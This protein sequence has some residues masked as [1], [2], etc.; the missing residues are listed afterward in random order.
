MTHALEI[1]PAMSTVLPPSASPVVSPAVSTV[2]PATPLASQPL[3]DRSGMRPMRTPSLGGR[4]TSA[5]G[6]RHTRQASALKLARAKG[7]N[8]GLMGRTRSHSHTLDV[9]LP[10]HS[11][12]GLVAL[13]VTALPISETPDPSP[14][15]RGM[16]RSSTS[17]ALHAASL[18]D[19]EDEKKDAVANVKINPEE[20]GKLD[21][22][23]QLRLLAM[24]E[25]EVVEVKDAIKTLNSALARQEQE[26][27]TLKQ[28]VQRSLYKEVG[29]GGV[30]APAAAPP[31][32][33]QAPL[34]PLPA[35]PAPASLA[36]PALRAP[37][38]A[39]NNRTLWSLLSKP[40]HYLNQFDSML[41]AEFEKSI[42]P[43]P[44]P[45]PTDAAP[46][47]PM[48]EAGTNLW[49]FVS[50]VKNNIMSYHDDAASGEDVEMGMQH[51]REASLSALAD[52]SLQEVGAKPGLVPP[53]GPTRVPSLR[54]PKRPS[55]PAP[56]RL[57]VEELDF[58]ERELR[59]ALLE[60]PGSPR[61]ALPTPHI[62]KS[63][64]T[65]PR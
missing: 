61:Q 35:R 13:N 33:S 17:A 18:I 47:S 62:R 27:H 5:L 10:L 29:R 4:H 60:V 11:R 28:M 15:K 44:P 34:A 48:A 2:V 50:E 57:P 42:N 41:Q 9:V 56:K 16:V 3:P 26:L 58:F 55:V 49:L 43:G 45:P 8:L 23:D 31:P 20:V 6:S 24:K 21:I 52:M 51:A 53:R 1:P 39:A 40:L 54:I 38:A 7:L 22:A 37:G 46:S 63:S 30:A 64:G 65:R 32:A 14:S 25:M 19:E 59:A 36:P 12:K